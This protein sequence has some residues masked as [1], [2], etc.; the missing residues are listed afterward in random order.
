MVI[1]FDLLV[2]WLGWAALLNLAYLLLATLLILVFKPWISS[3]HA[4]LFGLEEARLPMAYFTFLG[5]YKLVT[6]AFFVLPY[7]AARLFL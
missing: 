1:T 3:L 7:L 5:Y 4:R 2:S 6:M